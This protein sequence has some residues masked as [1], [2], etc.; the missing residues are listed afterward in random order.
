MTGI[1]H[2]ATGLLLKSRF[3]FAP[4][5]LLVVAA[6]TTDLIWA[7]LNFLG[8]GTLPALEFSTID[9]PFLY[10]GSMHLELQPYS[11]SLTGCLIQGAFFSSLLWLILGDRRIVLPVF[12]AVL[13]HWCLDFLVHDKDL[14]LLPLAD[15]ARVGPPVVL[16]A[17]QPTLGLYSVHPIV[18]YL[19]QTMI[20]CICVWIFLRAYPVQERKHL[21]IFL[22]IILIPIL[23]A[24]PT[25]WKGAMTAMVAGVANL[26]GGVLVDALVAGVAIYCALRFMNRPALEDDLDLTQLD[27]GLIRGS[28]FIAVLL[29]LF[30]I[31]Q[32]L[33]A[34]AHTSMGVWT[35]V[36]A[37]LYAGIAAALKFA[38][39]HYRLILHAAVTIPVALGSAVRIFVGPG[40]IGIFLLGLELLLVGMAVYRLWLD[41]K[42]AAA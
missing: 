1:A 38:P 42:V 21:F 39:D 34:P 18:G 4:V 15:A 27:R 17:A 35:W 19:F 3:K 9:L 32:G 5:M 20:V 33:L 36:F 16:D 7:V 2:L 40:Q 13:G 24:L 10:I 30:Y 28:I 12:L 29:A 25:F 22:G 31:L 11:H 37:L 14:S 8:L 23:A 6:G 26:I 41:R